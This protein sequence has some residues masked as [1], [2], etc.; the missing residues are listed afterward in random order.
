MPRKHIPDRWPNLS[1]VMSISDRYVMT[2]EALSVSTFTCENCNQKCEDKRQNDGNHINAD[3]LFRLVISI[4]ANG[5]ILKLIY[6]SFLDLL[7]MLTY[8][9]NYYDY[10]RCD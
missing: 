2:T 8:F 7:K 1:L 5:S 4:D 6:S 9:C 10:F 3:S